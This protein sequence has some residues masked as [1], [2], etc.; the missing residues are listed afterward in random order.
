MTLDPAF[1][2]SKE[3]ISPSGIPELQV[4]LEEL[5]VRV[6]T[7]PEETPANTPSENT[8]PP[9]PVQAGRFKMAIPLP[10]KHRVSVD[11]TA[12]KETFERD[13]QS[14]KNKKLRLSRRGK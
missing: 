11:V 14:L 6:T 12:G 8:D 10:L 7:L 5:I 9:R 4:S 2:D 3:I 13:V 1:R